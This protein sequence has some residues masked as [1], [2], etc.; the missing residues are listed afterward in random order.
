MW[1][2]LN[3]VTVAVLVS[4]VRVKEWDSSSAWGGQPLTSCLPDPAL[5]GF[6]PLPLPQG[7]RAPQPA[8]PPPPRPALAAG[9]DTESS[10]Q[11]YRDAPPTSHLV[12]VTQLIV[13]DVP[14]GLVWLRP[15][16]CDAVGCP[17][18]LVHHRDCRGNWGGESVGGR[19]AWGRGSKEAR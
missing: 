18:H 1:P 15:G 8:L 9:W 11:P 6:R 16:H 7:C 13:Q 19:R 5:Q 2:G 4:L 14:V 3:C 12:V 10:L 17:A